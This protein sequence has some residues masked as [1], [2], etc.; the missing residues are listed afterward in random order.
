LL[1]PEYW[2][3]QVLSSFIFLP[4]WWGTKRLKHFYRRKGK[5]FCLLNHSISGCCITRTM[6]LLE[7]HKKAIEAVKPFIDTG[8]FYLAGGTAV[9]YYLGHRESIDLDFFT[10]ADIDF[11]QYEHFIHPHSILFRSK[12]TIH[13][14]VE[15]IKMSFFHYPYKLLNPVNRLDVISIAHLEDVLCVITI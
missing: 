15:Q 9:Y 14:D 1:L 7:Q 8:G 10:K 2:N 5:D 4:N 6:T 11:L 13:A 12:H 3:S